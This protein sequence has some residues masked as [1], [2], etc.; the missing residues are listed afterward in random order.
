M[1]KTSEVCSQNGLALDELTDP[2]RLS[3][4]GTDQQGVERAVNMIWD[5]IAIATKE[6]LAG[7]DAADAAA[8]EAPRASFG[9]RLLTK[10]I[11]HACG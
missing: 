8:V 4:R 3:I 5:S 11:K 10:I 7:L 6:E 1:S 9:E 2:H